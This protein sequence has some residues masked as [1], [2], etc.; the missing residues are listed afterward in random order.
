MKK[1]IMA[2]VITACLA[3]CAAVWP[4]SEVVEEV[5]TTPL[6][7]IVTATQSEIP[8]PPEPK[9]LITPEKKG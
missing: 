3:L 6:P 9:E 4:Q 7:P 1:P 8:E 2:T 5:P